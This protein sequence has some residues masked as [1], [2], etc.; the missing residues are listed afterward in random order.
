M[1]SLNIIWDCYQAAGG[2]G[3][4][5]TMSRRI[6][7]LRNVHQLMAHGVAITSY[8]YCHLSKR[9]DALRICC[10]AMLEEKSVDYTRLNR[11]ANLLSLPESCGLQELI[12]AAQGANQEEVMVT[13]ARR[14]LICL[15]D[16]S[17]AEACYVAAQC[18]NRSSRANDTIELQAQLAAKAATYCSGECLLDATELCR[19]VNLRQLIHKRSTEVGASPDVY[20]SVSSLGVYQDFTTPIL[21]R[22]IMKYL[23]TA[24]ARV[25]PSV[26][27]ALGTNTIVGV[28]AR[29]SVKEA[30][31]VLGEF[32]KECLSVVQ[33]LRGCRQLMPA[34]YVA[35]ASDSLVQLLFSDLRSVERV[36]VYNA[37]VAKHFDELSSQLLVRVMT[38]NRPEV[39]DMALATSCLLILGPQE[40][41]KYLGMGTCFSLQDLCFI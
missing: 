1:S 8:D 31:V 25:L 6:A 7:D 27:P 41:Y 18:L 10:A 4:N 28:S 34:L 12:L 23:S 20:Q 3:D 24:Q 14:L 19:L 9:Q 26:K 40:G 17:M 5:S 37:A 33:V 39:P 36:S 30:A 29:V 38:A 16:A 2:Q 21:N 35:Y 13:C 15:E 32:A 22:D 11:V